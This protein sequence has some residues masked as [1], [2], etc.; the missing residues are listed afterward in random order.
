M[1]EDD[2]VHPLLGKWEA[3]EPPAAMDARIRA[4]W[5][6]G[7]HERRTRPEGYLG[8]RHLAAVLLVI[9]AL[10]IVLRPLPRAAHG[11]SGYVTRLGAAGFQPLPDG[12]A[13]VVRMS[14]VRQ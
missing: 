7:L 1:T 14:E 5:R 9:F 6:A 4:A 3:P 11:E 10:L 13:R 2:P 8:L 12:A